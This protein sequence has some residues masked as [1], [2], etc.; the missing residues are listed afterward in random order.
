MKTLLTIIFSILFNNSFCQI[1]SEGIGCDNIYL[2]QSKKT[3][4]KEIGKEFSK[5]KVNDFNYIVYKNIEVGFDED[6]IIDE[7]VVYPISDLKTING[8]IIEQNTLVRK[9]VEKFGDEWGYSGESPVFLDY[10]NGISFETNYKLTADKSKD[11]SANA[12]FLNSK[13]ISVV[14]SEPDSILE[15]NYIHYEYIDGTYIPKNLEETFA[16]LEKL[17]KKNDKKEIL[18]ISEQ[19]FLS[20]QHFALGLYIRNEW[21]LWKKSR[22]YNYF[23]EKNLFHPDDISTVILK[24][25]Y[26]KKKKLGFY[27]EGEINYYIEYW[28]NK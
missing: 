7:I 25:Y 15:N 9:I 27:L 13:I 23:I 14:I 28:K 5:K 12:D 6:D 18:K 26:C 20:S 3:L 22:L 24:H 1:I 2:G 11:L 16:E 21:G 17:L 8:K 19:D 4:I 10:E